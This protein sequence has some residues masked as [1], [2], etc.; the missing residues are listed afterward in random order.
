LVGFGDPVFDPAK[1]AEA[2]AERRKQTRVAVTRGYG[3][4]W[5]GQSIDQAKLAQHLPPL[6]DTADELKAVAGKLGAAAGDVHLGS[7]ASEITSESPS[8]GLS[9]RHGVHRCNSA[10]YGAPFDDSHR[11]DP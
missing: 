11:A 7:D 3:E 9:R 6:L 1:R 10:C 2:L 4:F 5:Q 8:L